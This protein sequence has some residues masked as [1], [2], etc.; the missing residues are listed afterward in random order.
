MKKIKD[1]FS[2]LLAV[3]PQDSETSTDPVQES[4]PAEKKAPVKKKPPTKKKTKKS[5]VKPVSEYRFN[6]ID[7]I[8]TY[9]F[10]KQTNPIIKAAGRK[11]KTSKKAAPNRKA[12]A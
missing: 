6:Q 2:F 12:A 5:A 1:I 9:K 7:S 11:G 4:A 3:F 8:P 10:D